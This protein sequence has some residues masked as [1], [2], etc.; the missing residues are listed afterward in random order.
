MGKLSSIDPIA[1]QVALKDGANAQKI[2]FS[3]FCTPPRTVLRLAAGPLALGNMT[4][5]VADADLAAENVF[6]GLSVFQHL[7]VDTKTLFEERRDLL[8]CANCFAIKAASAGIRGVQVSRLMITR[9]HRV[10]NDFV[11][12]NHC[13]DYSRARI[14]YYNVNEEADPFPGA[15]LL[16]WVNSDQHV[17]LNFA[18]K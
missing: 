15:S 12:D 4:V 10:S 13:K 5:L 6:I 17:E 8:D 11:E 14:N 16:N 9:V 1:L 18:M 7:G 3:H 2:T